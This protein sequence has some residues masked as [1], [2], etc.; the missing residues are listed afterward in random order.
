[1]SELSL[2]LFQVRVNFISPT[3]DMSPSPL[4]AWT[5]FLALWPL[6]RATL[7]ITDPSDVI[8][9]AD[10]AADNAILA[11]YN[12]TPTLYQTEAIVGPYTYNGEA[13]NISHATLTVSKNDTSVLVVS[14]DSDVSVE[15]S[16]IIKYGYSSNLFQASFYG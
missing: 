2:D 16:T 7:T 13:A 4:V 10:W 14:N 1:M 3:T 9:P 12:V 5:S 6:A 15:Y 11:D 8:N